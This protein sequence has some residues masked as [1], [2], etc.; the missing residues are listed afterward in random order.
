[1]AE[2]CMRI[3]TSLYITVSNYGA[4]VGIHR[5]ASLNDRDTF[6]EMRR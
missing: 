4:V 1:M 2:K 6:W 3:T 5:Y